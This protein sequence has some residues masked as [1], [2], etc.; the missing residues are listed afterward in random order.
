[1]VTYNVDPF[2][3]RRGATFGTTGDDQSYDEERA[4]DAARDNA[5]H[6][7]AWPLP[8]A[9]VEAPDGGKELRV[10]YEAENEGMSGKRKVVQAHGRLRRDWVALGILVAN[11]GGPKEGGG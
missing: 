8:P 2:P 5:Q 9:H 6:H 11:G 4:D 7:P 3:A 1:M 10:R